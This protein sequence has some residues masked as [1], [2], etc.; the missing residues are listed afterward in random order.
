MRV[1]VAGFWRNK[2]QFKENLS[3]S[4]KLWEQKNVGRQ[5]TK[6]VFT[7]DHFT[8]Y[9]HTDMTFTFLF[10]VESIGALNGRQKHSKLN[11]F[12]CLETFTSE[13][14]VLLTQ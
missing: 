5:L 1:I 11:I 9:V 12:L 6:I 3:Q 13:M 14:I 4:A 8:Q 2:E 7:A 10:Y